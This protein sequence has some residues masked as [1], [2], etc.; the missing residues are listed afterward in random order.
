MTVPEQSRSGQPNQVQEG[1]QGLSSQIDL[2]LPLELRVSALL[3]APPRT[4]VPLSKLL[5]FPKY[6]V[7]EILFP[8]PVLRSDTSPRGSMYPILRYSGFG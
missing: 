2:A 3:V 4:S 5:I 1:S 8:A 6:H 7:P